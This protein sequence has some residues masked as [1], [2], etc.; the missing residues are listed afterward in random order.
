MNLQRFRQNLRF[1]VGIAVLSVLASSPTFAQGGVTVSGRVVNEV[2]DPVVGITIAIQPYKVMG[3]RREEGFI[4]RW[5]R[6]TD[7]EG[8]FSITNIMPAESVR[9]VVHPEQVEQGEQTEIA[10]PVYRNG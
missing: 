10:N 6:Q 2:A 3:N 5:Q 8:H 7:S 9:F 1:L 4:E